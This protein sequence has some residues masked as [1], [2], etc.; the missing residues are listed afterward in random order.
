MNRPPVRFPLRAISAVSLWKW[1]TWSLAAVSLIA[2][3]IAARLVQIEI[4]TSRLQARYLQR[5]ESRRKHPCGG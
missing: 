3:V 4:E 5:I 1:L 2:L